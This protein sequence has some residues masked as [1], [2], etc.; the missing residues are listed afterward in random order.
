M[1]GPSENSGK[2]SQLA[3]S[4]V[5]YHSIILHSYGIFSAYIRE[6]QLV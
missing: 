5:L 3:Y 2:Y 6:K 1:N 4:N